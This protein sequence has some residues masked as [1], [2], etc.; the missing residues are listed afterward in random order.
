[1]SGFNPFGS[2]GGM[3]PTQN[4]ISPGESLT[5]P[6]SSAMSLPSV[7]GGVG[8]GG[9]MGM[10]ATP[11]VGAALGVVSTMFGALFGGNDQAEQQAYQAEIQRQEQEKARAAQRTEGARQ[12]LMNAFT[13]GIN[14]ESMSS[15]NISNALSRFL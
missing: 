6:V 9:I 1:M 11:G 4:F 5:A 3:G 12:G 7:A 10:L 14:V 2:Y 15:Q 13:Q 8:G